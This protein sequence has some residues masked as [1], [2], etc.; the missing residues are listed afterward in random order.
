MYTYISPLSPYFNFPEVPP[1]RR[2]VCTAN[3]SFPDFAEDKMR[4]ENE[5]KS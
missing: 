4:L 3:V 1:Y 5:N 2:T